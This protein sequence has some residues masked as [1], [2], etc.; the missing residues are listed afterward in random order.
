MRG[1]FLFVLFFLLLFTEGVEG[2][3]Q[4]ELIDGDTGEPLKDVIVH[5]DL[6]DDQ[7]H[8]IKQVVYVKD[9][10]T[11]PVSASRYIGSLLVD[12]PQT[13][14]PDYYF[15]GSLLFDTDV[16]SLTFMPIA[17]VRGEV[18]DTSETLV[19]VADLSFRCDR[20]ST[21]S[22]P[23]RTDKYG[24]FVTY[25]PIGTCLIVATKDKMTGQETLV[26]ERGMSYDLVVS[27]DQKIAGNYFWVLVVVLL[28][29]AVVWVMRKKVIRSSRSLSSSQRKQSYS[30][31]LENVLKT[32][33]E[34]EK[35]VVMVLLEGK[36]TLSA[37]H[38]RHQ[39]KIPKTSFSR[40]LERL[41]KK[42]LI[43]VESDGAF[44]KVRLA[45]WVKKK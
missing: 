35:S 2:K 45:D 28:G 43:I 42:Q 18:Y 19:S 30:R 34:K 4:V 21:L 24:S 27:M 9:V 11:M 5:L 6:V 25:V 44:K 38:I 36:K 10:L 41:E 1:V 16:V 22:F 29:I 8:T 37:S 20:L 26:A 32:L 3:Q 15:S 39:V 17:S 12:D 7:Q 33:D 23:A 14:A 40:V 31:E 13:P